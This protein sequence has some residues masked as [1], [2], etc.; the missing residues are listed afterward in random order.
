MIKKIRLLQ[1]VIIKDKTVI[2][3]CNLDV[4]IVNGEVVETSKIKAVIP[5]LEHLLKNNCK[6][7]I[8]SHLGNPNGK[9]SDE[10]SLM[11][12]RFEIGK[13]L[14]KQLKFANIDQCEN[15]VKFMEF[16][17]ILLLE[18]LGF[19]FEETSTSAVIRKNFVKKLSDMADVYVNE[20]F[21]VFGKYASA[22]ELPVLM[23]G[24]AGLAFQNELL[25]LNKLKS[26]VKKPYT[27]IL[28][29]KD[30][31][32]KIEDISK[33]LGKVDKMLIGG[34]IAF[35]FL[36]AQNISVGDNFVDF[37]ILNNIRNFLKAAKKLNTEIF[38][39]LDYIGI[40]KNN[41][42]VNINTQEIPDGEKALDIGN[43][44]IKAF[45]EQILGSKTLLWYGPLGKYEI[46]EF[47]NGTQSLA[48]M[49]TLESTQDS[50]KVVGGDSTINALNLLKIKIKRFN[51]LSNSDRML[52]EFLNN[53]SFEVINR[54]CEE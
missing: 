44:T 13:L 9:Y 46:K 18:N 17:D 35:S 50:F 32:N 7:I 33:L 34:E 2:V 38:L 41:N 19:S 11:P 6:V 23:K 31:G 54:L 28:G 5:T 30:I 29:G 24:C 36:K 27:V 45:K 43:K 26:E 48:E 42:I 3:R 39:P 49:I 16:G 22:Y 21:G 40:D 4:S 12:V 52:L 20:S 1:D 10:F 14:Q 51:H 25:Q 47:S 8:L 53:K 15:S 37:K